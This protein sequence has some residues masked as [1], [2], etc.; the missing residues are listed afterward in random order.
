VRCV[1]ALAVFYINAAALTRFDTAGGFE[2]VLTLPG[3]RD[4]DRDP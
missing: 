3:E 1:P 4:P 2:V